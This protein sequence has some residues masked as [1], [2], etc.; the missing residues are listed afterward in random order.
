VKKHLERSTQSATQRSLP[1]PGRRPTF[2]DKPGPGV[3]TLGIHRWYR[4]YN[5][6]HRG[7]GYAALL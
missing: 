6:A 7:D 4:L 5:A 2:A 1:G 3:A